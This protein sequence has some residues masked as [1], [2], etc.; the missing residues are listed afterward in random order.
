MVVVA[1]IWE[2]G[3]NTPI[4][5]F[6]LWHYPLRDFG[7]DELAMTPV[8]GIATN[9]VR[10]FHSVEDI[11]Q[12]YELPVV[13]CSEKGEVE[14]GEFEHPKDA[15]YLFNRTSGGVLPGNHDYSIRI[16]TKQNKG[17][18]WGHQAASIILYDRFKKWQ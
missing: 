18:L 14:L 5:E 11:I 17:L 7:V 1:G 3:W 2:S 8:S 16:E 13:I 10:E 4:K 15:L 6:D 9:K 12:H